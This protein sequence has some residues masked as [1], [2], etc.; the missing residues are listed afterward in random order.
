MANAVEPHAENAVAHY[1]EEV[2]SEISKVVWPTRE[3]V[4]N[5]SIV[6]M[7]VVV[8]MAIFFGIADLLFGEL[9]KGILNLLG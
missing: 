6:V 5:L 4:I 9:V 8:T 2:R 3:Q 1:L 7:T